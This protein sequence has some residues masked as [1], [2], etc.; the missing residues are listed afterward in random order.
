MESNSQID[1]FTDLFYSRLLSRASQESG[2]SYTAKLLNSGKSKILQK[3]GEEA[4]EV[5]LAGATGERNE[6]VSEIADLYYHVMVLMVSE[7]VRP[8]EIRAELEK[9]MAISG[10]EEKNSRMS[11]N[12]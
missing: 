6:L 10:I 1:G 7:K 9:R 11:G 8:E 3:V 4:V 2:S 5:V 12:E